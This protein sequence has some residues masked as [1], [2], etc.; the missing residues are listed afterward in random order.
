MIENLQG[1]LL[2]LENKQAN[3]AKLVLILDRSKEQKNPLKLS[4]K[5]SVH[6]IS[7]KLVSNWEQNMLYNKS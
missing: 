7:P 3:V 5:Y 2:K 6:E 1:E 4:S